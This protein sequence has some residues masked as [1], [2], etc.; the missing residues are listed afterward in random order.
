MC[1][2]A[3]E[4]GGG[5]AAGMT[6]RHDRCK[7]C[8]MLSHPA[9]ISTPS[10][11]LVCCRHAFKI[12]SPCPSTPTQHH[13]A[14]HQEE[15][16]VEVHDLVIQPHAAV[17]AGHLLTRQRPRTR[18][19]RQHLRWGPRGDGCPPARH[20]LTCGLPG[21]WWGVAARGWGGVRGGEQAPSVEWVM[22][23][24][25]VAFMPSTAGLSASNGPKACLV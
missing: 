9:V 2:G 12:P 5:G 14:A 24:G 23:A 15:A 17:Q 22:T 7:Q 16:D 18:V 11:R 3:G 10:C 4:V 20:L 25:G 8:C 1:G 6:G 13:P 19:V 21:A